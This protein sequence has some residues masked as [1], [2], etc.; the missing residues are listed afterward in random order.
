MLVAALETGRREFETLQEAQDPN[1]RQVHFA[2]L[3]GQGFDGSQAGSRG[4][5]YSLKM[6]T[7]ILTTDASVRGYN[8][9]P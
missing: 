3:P 9:S 7:T 8:I 5:F 6:T 2:L 4:E 1:G